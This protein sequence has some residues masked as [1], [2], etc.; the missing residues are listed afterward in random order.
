MS[1]KDGLF[2]RPTRNERAQETASKSISGAVGVDNLSF[3][4]AVDGEDLG[5]FRICCSNENGGVGALGDDDCAR[6]RSI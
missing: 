3:L 4:Q 2:Y 6:P 1:R 5:F